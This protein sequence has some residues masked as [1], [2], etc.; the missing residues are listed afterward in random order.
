MGTATGAPEDLGDEA[1][2]ERAMSDAVVDA[3][4]TQPR[5]L[6]KMLPP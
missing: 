4:V 5:R 6:G 3:V 2:A 1:G